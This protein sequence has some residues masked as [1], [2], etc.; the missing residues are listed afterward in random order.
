MI[1][2]SIKT[3]EAYR[4]ATPGSQM[5]LVWFFGG[6]LG[7]TVWGERVAVVGPQLPH[8]TTQGCR[9]QTQ[10]RDFPVE[11]EL[12]KTDLYQRGR[13]EQST[14]QGPQFGQGPGRG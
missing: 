1:Y 5:G 12:E 14:Q 2:V 8:R 3:T 7:G 6:V 9:C 13:L 10:I 4:L 11:K